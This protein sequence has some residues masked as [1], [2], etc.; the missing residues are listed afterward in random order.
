[1]EATTGHHEP[2]SLSLSP[3]HL[4]F[5]FF[6]PPSASPLFFPS[7]AEVAVTSS[8]GD[9]T[10]ISNETEDLVGPLPSSTTNS[11]SSKDFGDIVEGDLRRRCVA[12]FVLPLL[13]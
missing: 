8:D 7:T 9:T 6:S 2:P 1:M 10:T 4:T 5:T 13:A 11:T 3:E 12:A